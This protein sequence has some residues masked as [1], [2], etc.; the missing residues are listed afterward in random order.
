MKSDESEMKKLAYTEVTSLN[1]DGKY[2]YYY[3]GGSGSGAG[4]GLG[5]VLSTTG[6]YRVNKKKS[7]RC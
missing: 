3:Q 4:T 6:V 7:K 1:A 2:L 5:F